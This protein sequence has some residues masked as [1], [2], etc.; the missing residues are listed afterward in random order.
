MSYRRLPSLAMLLLF[1]N[2]RE[3]GKQKQRHTFELANFH[4]VPFIFISLD[5]YI[6]LH[7]AHKLL[8]FSCLKSCITMVKGMCLYDAI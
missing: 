7:E 2:N 1:D 3:K 8:Y 4:I 5:R 6:Y